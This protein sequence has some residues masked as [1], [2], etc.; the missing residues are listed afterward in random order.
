MLAEHPFMN[1][2]LEYAVLILTYKGLSLL[3]EAFLYS[4]FS[5]DP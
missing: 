4:S 1:V 2:S 3:Y 5:F